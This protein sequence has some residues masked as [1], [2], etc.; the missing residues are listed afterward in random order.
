MKSKWFNKKEEAIRLRKKGNSIRD[1]ETKLGISRSTLSGW[2]KNIQLTAK[3]EQVL[4]KKWKEGLVRARKGAVKW[5]NTQKNKRLEVAKREAGETLK[6]ISLDDKNILELSLAILYLGEGYKGST[7]TGIGSS[8]PKIL[9]LFL[10]SLE[11]VYNFDIKS[12][13]CELNLRADQSP[14]E[15]KKYWSKTLD[16]PIEN[17]KQATLDKRTEGRK[18]YSHYHGVCQLRCGRVDIQRRLMYLADMYCEDIISK[19]L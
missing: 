3:Q 12:I 11:Q 15:E 4:K 18:T 10:A 13:R 19:Y 7:G 5:H 14:E 2:F 6:N 8:D 1:I 17:F 16:I 9:R